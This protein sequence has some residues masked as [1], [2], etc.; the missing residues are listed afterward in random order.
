M[1]IEA[2]SLY[3]LKVKGGWWWKGVRPRFSGIDFRIFASLS[4]VGWGH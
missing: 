2:S 3:Q 1:W 4:K